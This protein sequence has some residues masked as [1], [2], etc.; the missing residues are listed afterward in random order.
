MIE[1]GAGG[2][3]RRISHCLFHDWSRVYAGIFHDQHLAWMCQI[4]ARLN[5]GVLPGSY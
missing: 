2:D 3:K 1:G 5:T 4:M